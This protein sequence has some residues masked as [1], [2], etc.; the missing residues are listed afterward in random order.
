MPNL[1]VN[2]R[3][4]VPNPSEGDQR[5]PSVVVSQSDGVLVRWARGAGGG[6]Y[7]IFDADGD[8]TGTSGSTSPAFL[9]LGP[10]LLGGGDV[11]TVTPNALVYRLDPTGQV[12]D[13]GALSGI[14]GSMGRTIELAGGNLLVTFSNIQSSST[15]PFGPQPMLNG[16]L[17]SPTLDQLGSSF[18]LGSQLDFSAG[19]VPLAGGG[20][21]VQGTGDQ[22]TWTHQAFDASGNP[23]SQ[24]LRTFATHADAAALPD[25]GYVLVTSSFGAGFASTQVQFFNASGVAT[26]DRL[27]VLPNMSVKPQVVVLDN[28]LYA[29]VFVDNIDG[30]LKAQLFHASGRALGTPQLL[31]QASLANVRIDGVYQWDAEGVDSDSFVTAHRDSGLTVANFF[32]FNNDA[33][34]LGTAAADELS[35][36]GEERLL[37]GLGG[38]DTYVVDSLGDEVDEKVNEGTADRVRT[39][40]DFTISASNNIEILQTTSNIGTDSLQLTGNALNQYIFGNYGAN[41]IDGGGGAD[42]M[43]GFAGNDTYFVD[44]AAD[45]VRENV[46]EGF[47]RISTAVSFTLQAGVEVEMLTSTNNI[48]TGSFDLVGNEFSQ[49][50]FG[51]FGANTLDGAGGADVMI[52][53]QGN[54]IY[55]VDD[56]SDEVREAAGALEGDRDIVLT[57]VSWRVGAGQ[58][59]ESLRASDLSSTAPIN[60]TGNEFTN[61]IDGNA[62]NNVL[63]GLG[64]AAILRGFGGDDT[65]LITSDSFVQEEGAGQGFDRVFVNGSYTLG[66]GLFI[67]VLTPI[68]EFGTAPLAMRGNSVA[69]YVYGNDGN[70]I[71][72]GRGGGDI[73]VGRG[74]DDQLWIY[75]PTDQIREEAN[76]GFDRVFSFISYRLDPGVSVEMMTTD[77]NGGTGSIN[78]TGNELAQYLFGNDGSN[79]LNG[80]AGRDVL[81]GFGGSDFFVFDTALNTGFTP[82]FGTLPDSANVDRIDG[83][84]FDDKIVLSGALFGLTPGALPAGA[85]NT[86]TTATDADDRVLWDS[87]SGALLFDADG[88]GGASAQLI[89]F[90]SSP[91][92][93]DSTFIVVS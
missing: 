86:G 90:L 54:D 16:V 9:Y 45:Q 71:I 15:P 75:D 23:L 77:N 88:A 1:F 26:S 83:F 70:N 68:D 17:L 52:G 32:D 73:L 24:K 48:G 29:I 40:V 84:G 82:S 25:G 79:R 20:F 30:D 78:L 66:G 38:D 74:G 3:Q 19:I 8:L 41:R 47:D 11:V 33:L 12:V 89:C 53:F 21:V 76:D 80:G 31:D 91:F 87:A 62:G 65:Y 64:R 4:V 39:S 13:Q 18:Q 37:V 51:N 55:F 22:G 67:E 46:G 44:N 14:N 56:A 72:E 50:L 49:Y 2:T 36:V 60:L 7:R 35:G 5:H 61:A 93:L 42:V 85:F 27:T 63:D 57:S 6:D 28:D 81:N 43:L 58:A 69:Q 59:V 10:T 34:R 92:S